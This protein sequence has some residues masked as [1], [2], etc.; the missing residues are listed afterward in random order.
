MP[1]MADIET[2]V[3]YDITCKIQSRLL[4]QLLRADITELEKKIDSF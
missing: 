2:Q 3:S 4:K 1:T